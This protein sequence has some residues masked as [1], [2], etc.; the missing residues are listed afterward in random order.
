MTNHNLHNLR[1]YCSF[2]NS[3]TQIMSDVKRT[4]LQPTRLSSACRLRVVARP[5]LNPKPRHGLNPEMTPSKDGAA[6][7]DEVVLPATL[8]RDAGTC[9]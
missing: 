1:D 6:T 2:P 9:L 7:D 5:A 4:S 3:C 8:L